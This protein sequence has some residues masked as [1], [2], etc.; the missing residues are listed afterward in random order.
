MPK[1]QT[2]FHQFLYFFSQ[3]GF[4]LKHLIPS[5]CTKLAQCQSFGRGSVGN[6]VVFSSR[7]LGQGGPSASLFSSLLPTASPGVTHI[8]CLLGTFMSQ[9]NPASLTENDP[10][11][12]C[13]ASERSQP[14]EECDTRRCPCRGAC[15]W[16][17]GSGRE[18]VF[19]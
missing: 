8:G 5:T 3:E 11:D 2:N 18:P 17:Q 1:P 19:L 13:W 9:I 16:E 7:C 10:F 14:L 12:F 15:G 6:R 4:R